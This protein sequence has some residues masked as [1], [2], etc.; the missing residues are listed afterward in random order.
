VRIR[1]A[2][3]KERQFAEIVGLDVSHR[4]LEIAHDRLHYDR[5]PPVQKERLRLLHGSLI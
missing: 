1:Q 4:A 2:L 5:L 3:L